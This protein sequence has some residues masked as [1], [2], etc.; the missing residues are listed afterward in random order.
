MY[1]L[2]VGMSEPLRPLGRDLY[3]GLAQTPLE[4]PP[5]LDQMGAWVHLCDVLSLS[6]LEQQ[7][8]DRTSHVSWTISAVACSLD[9]LRRLCC[10]LDKMDVSHRI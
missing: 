3:F 7:S 6:A 2:R 4:H 1:V 9:I 8:A 5:M 10:T